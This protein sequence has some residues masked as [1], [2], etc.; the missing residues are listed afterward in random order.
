MIRTLHIDIEGGWGGSSR[1]LFELLSRLDHARIRPLVAH[2]QE[3]PIVERYAEIGIPTAHV[4]EIFS[5]APRPRNSTK[6]FLANFPR[7]RHLRRAADRLADLARGHDAQIVHLN[8]EG[9]FLLAPM[10][11]RRLGLPMVCHSRTLIPANAWGRWMVRTLARSA[12]HMFFISSQEEERFGALEPRPAVPGDVLWNISAAPSPRRLLAAVPEAVYLGNIDPSKGTDRLIDIAASLEDMSA[13]PLIIAVYGRPRHKQ[14]YLEQME[15]RIDRLGLRHRIDL[16]GYEAVP[17]RVL[18]RALAL[19]R[20]SRENDPWG[21]D[22]IEATTCG[23][24]VLATGSYD[25]VVE[26]GVTGYLFDPFD[27]AALAQKLV[28]LLRDPALR[29]RLGAAGRAK[30]ALKFSGVQ[31]VETV[32]RVFEK[33]ARCRRVTVAA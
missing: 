28:E 10:L 25:G 33:L 4:P 9:L 32:T 19:I 16:C 3:G 29:E 22:V 18:A 5:Y 14:D 15:R 11:K 17:E 7:M 24:P 23:V 31:Q 20:P 30:G 6:I 8:Y 27:A 13:P 12:D 21:R 1:S 2:R 26:P